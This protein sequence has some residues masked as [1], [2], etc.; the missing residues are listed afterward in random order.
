MRYVLLIVLA[1]IAWRIARQALRR[2]LAALRGEPPPPEPSGPR[3][4]DLVAIA[5]VV[6]YG[7]YA[8]WHIWT[9]SG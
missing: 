9:A 2:R 4:I 1:F 3:P 7:A 8:L 6:I 5:L